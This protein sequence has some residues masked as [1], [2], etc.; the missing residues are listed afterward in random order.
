MK[1]LKATGRVGVTHRT[2]E[3]DIFY[4]RDHT[5]FRNVSINDEDYFKRGEYTKSNG[6]VSNVNTDISLNYSK[7]WQE[8]HVLYANGQWSM[9][10]NKSESVAVKA[11]GFANNKL[12]YI[13]HALQYEEG[14]KPTGSESLSRETSV[15]AS[16]CLLYTSDAA[17]E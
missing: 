13:T 6:K 2:D 1:D 8:K 5:K 10:Q 17:D 15:L 16:I 3:S 9:S 11:Q 7:I 12:D 14:G 4:P